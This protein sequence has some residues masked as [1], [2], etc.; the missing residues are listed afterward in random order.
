MTQHMQALMDAAY[1]AW[2]QEPGKSYDDFIFD[3]CGTQK[4]AVLLGNLNY[5]V[6]N[7]GFSQW[8]FN[9]YAEFSA[10][11]RRVL[12]RIGTPAAREVRELVSFVIEAG[13]LNDER[14][15]SW[16]DDHLD[17]SEQDEAYYKINE[18]LLADAEAYFAK[19]V[20]QTA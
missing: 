19:K 9:G 12:D 15:R 20:L 18:Q 14:R 13:R 17:L 11:V 4:E 1:T 2:Q 8:I 5:Q 10:D 6:E 3:L 7:G 16:D